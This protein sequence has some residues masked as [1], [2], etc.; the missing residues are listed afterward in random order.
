MAGKGGPRPN[1]GRKPGVP[2]KANVERA[3]LA[4]RIIEEQAGKP[5]QKLAREVLNDF[6]QLFTGMAAM[7]QPL[8]IG[9]VPMNG[10]M[11]D[12][13]K[14]LEFAKL[15]IDTA[16]QLAPYQSPKLKAVLISQETPPGGHV[17][18]M[19]QADQLGA[20]GSLSPQE[21]YRLLR[22]ADVIDVTPAAQLVDGKKI[23]KKVASQ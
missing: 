19:G 12:P 9:V 13:S 16:A 18:G 5:G 2:N 17:G 11:P 3:L 22:D 7:H 10:Q 23:A 15:A 4:K 14:F 20:M 8:P 6:M 21:A 1:A